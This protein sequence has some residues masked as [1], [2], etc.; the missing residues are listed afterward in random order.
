MSR[1]SLSNTNC[2]SIKKISILSKSITFKIFSSAHHPSLSIAASN[3][4]SSIRVSEDF[5]EK[6]KNRLAVVLKY[7]DGNE[8][9]EMQCIYALQALCVKHQYPQGEV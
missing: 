2:S 3:D 5:E 7:V 8:M 1:A 6:M 4:G 9:L